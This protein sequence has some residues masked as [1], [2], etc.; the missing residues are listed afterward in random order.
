M[1]SAVSPQELR[2]AVN[3][4]G[5]SIVLAGVVSRSKL[6]FRAL[7]RVL[8]GYQDA[9]FVRQLVNQ[10]GLGGRTPLIAAA[11]PHS[12]SILV[13][14][15][16]TRHGNV[17]VL[18]P[19]KGCQLDQLRELELLFPVRIFCR[20]KSLNFRDCKAFSNVLPQCD[21]LCLS[22]RPMCRRAAF[23]L[24]PLMPTLPKMLRPILRPPP[25]Q[26]RPMPTSRTKTAMDRRRPSIASQ[27][28]AAQCTIGA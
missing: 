8:L 4:D 20:D 1:L 13:S 19:T 15:V 17:G 14:K 7:K 12:L 16:M 22:R 10:R 21:F 9:E 5:E 6:F 23:R 25:R 28:F 24:C 27:A 3:K 18:D 26:C 2:G 11:N